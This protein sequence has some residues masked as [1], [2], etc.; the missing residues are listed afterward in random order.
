VASP[1]VWAA[2]NFARKQQGHDPAGISPYEIDAVRQQLTGVNEK[3]ASAMRKWLDDFMISR[4]AVSQGTPTDQALVSH[5]LDLAR[6]DYRA[7]KR[8]QAVEDVNQYAGDRAEV[9]NSGRNV[10]NTYGQK[11]T[12]RFLNPQGSEYKWLT[13]DERQAVRSTARRDM[14]GQGQRILGNMMGGGGGAYTGLLVA[15]G[16]AAAFMSGDV[17]A[18]GALAVPA[19]GW[20][21]KSADNRAMVN[22]ANELADTFAKNSPL[23][24]SRAAN[25]PMVAG[26]GLGNF[27]ESNRNAVTMQ[28]LNQL[29]T[30]GYLGDPTQEEQP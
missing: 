4:H 2:L 28:L 17:K 21:L 11:L 26:P 12:N 29:K 20:A 5:W 1:K 23:Y 9:A 3:G 16:P 13:P 22:K 18:L 7:G 25:A 6:G 24:R 15:G 27:A 30:R 10:G 14:L 8:T 19:A